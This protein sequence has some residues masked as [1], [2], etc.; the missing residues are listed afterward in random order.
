MHAGLA[1]K[2]DLRR[3]SCLTRRYQLSDQRFLCLHVNRTERDQEY[4]HHHSPS[5]LQHKNFTHRSLNHGTCLL[6]LRF[7]IRALGAVR[8]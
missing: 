1:T 5:Q 7:P 6:M 8:P 3:R 4:R 2:P